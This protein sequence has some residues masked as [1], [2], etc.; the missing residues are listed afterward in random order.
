LTTILVGIRKVLPPVE[1]VTAMG[2]RLQALCAEFRSRVYP[3]GAV[4]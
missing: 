2:P 3:S 1:A 4:D